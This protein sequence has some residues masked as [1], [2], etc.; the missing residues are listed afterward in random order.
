MDSILR[1]DVV[2]QERVVV[3]AAYG[4]HLQQIHQIFQSQA[5]DSRME[6]DRLVVDE[7]WLCVFRV[8]E[9]A[10]GTLIISRDDPAS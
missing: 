6:E 7:N 10:L 4:R 1:W 9:T 2:H 5:L 8:S 3:S